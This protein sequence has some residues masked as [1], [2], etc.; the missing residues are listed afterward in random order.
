VLCHDRSFNGADARAQFENAHLGAIALAAQTPDDI[1]AQALA[2]GALHGLVSN[3]VHPNVPTP[4][5]DISMEALRESFEALVAFPFR[6]GQLALTAMKQQQGGAMVFVTSARELKPEPGFA[7][8]TTLRTATSSFAKAL[9]RE[10]APHQI[11]VNVVAPN[12]LYS[13]MYYP[14]AQ[15]IDNPEGRAKIASLVPFGRLGEPQEVGEMIAFMVS[16]RSAF[17]TGQV[18]YFTGGWP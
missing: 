14:R 10:A 6:L 4:V 11:P 7:L 1:V 3:D 18:I 5:E 9:A 12:Y 17:T 15:F 8:A 13:E 2:H 16:G